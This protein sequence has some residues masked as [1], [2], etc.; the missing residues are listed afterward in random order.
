M[1]SWQ[2]TIFPL[3]LLYHCIIFLTLIFK[4]VSLYYFTEFVYV[5]IVSCHKSF[6]KVVGEICNYKQVDI[7]VDFFWS[8]FLFET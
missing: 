1:T 7:K 3:V 8:Q 2:S 5:Y 4:I 6:M